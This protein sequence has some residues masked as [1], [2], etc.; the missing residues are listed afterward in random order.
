MGDGL[1]LV[2]PVVRDARDEAIAELL[3]TMRE[4]IDT[5][6]RLVDELVRERQAATQAKARGRKR[7]AA[8]RSSALVTPLTVPPEAHAAAERV[9]ARLGRS[10]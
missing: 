9:V 3:R 10:R 5:T 7:A 2:A 4:H 8:I 6:K 1:H